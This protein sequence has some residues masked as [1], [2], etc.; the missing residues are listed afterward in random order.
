ML[1]LQATSSSAA[2]TLE[3]G[4]IGLHAVHASVSLLRVCQGPP[5]KKMSNNRGDRALRGALDP[6]AP[7]R[8]PHLPLRI[9]LRMRC[10]Y[11]LCMPLCILRGACSDLDC[12]AMQIWQGC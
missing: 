7:N 10:A 1:L 9:S 11:L 8:A 2:A 5:G 6:D 12:N 3:S 4:A